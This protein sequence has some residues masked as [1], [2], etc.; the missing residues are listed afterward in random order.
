[1]RHFRWFSKC[2]TGLHAAAAVRTKVP[3]DKSTHHELFQCLHAADKPVRVGNSGQR[4]QLFRPASRLV[5]VLLFLLAALASAQTVF[6]G[7]QST[8]NTGST[9][10]SPQQVA[11]DASGDVFVLDDWTGHVSEMVAVNAVIPASPTINVLAN[12]HVFSGGGMVI[13][14][15]GNLFLT[16]NLS[17][18][19]YGMFEIP[20]SS[21]NANPTQLGGSFNTSNGVAL[22]TSGNVYVCEDGGVNDIKEISAASGYTTVTTPVTGLNSPT[23]VAVDGSGNIF[24]ADG[25]GISIKEFTASSSYASSTSLSMSFASIA[26]LAIDANGNLYAADGS[27]QALDE[28]LSAGGYST[29]VTLASGLTFPTGVAVTHSGNVFLADQAAVGA[30]DEIQ[31][32]AV[33]FG[34]VNMGSTGT[35]ISLTFAFTAAETIAAPSVLTQGFTGLDF[36]DAGTGTCT[37]NGT[38]HVYQS[39]DTCTVNVRFSPTAPRARSGSVVLL[40]SGSAI[41]TAYLTGTGVG[42]QVVFPNTNLIEIGAPDYGNLNEPLSIAVD[43]VGNVYVADYNFTTLIVLPWNCTY[44][45][46]TPST[47]GG[48]FSEPSS[49]AIDGA[50]NLYVADHGNGAIKEMP[51]NCAD[52]TCVTTLGGSF[53]QPNG[54]AVDSSGNVYVSDTGNYRVV[55]MPPGCTSSACVTP[56]GGGFATPQ[57]LWVDGSGNV[58]VADPYPNTVARYLSKIPQGC[59]SSACTVALGGGFSHPRGVAVDGSGNIYIADTTN[60]KLKEMPGTCTTSA[61]VTTLASSGYSGVN[62]PYG[63]FMTPGN[64]LYVTD[65]DNHKIKEIDQTDGPSLSYSSTAVGAS[66]TQ[67]V[68]ALSNYGNAPLTISALSGSS[69]NFSGAGTTCAI[70]TPLAA[71]ASCNLGIKFAPTAPGAPLTGSANITDNGYPASQ[72]IPVSGTATGQRPTVTGISPATGTSSGGT[73]ITITGSYFYSGATVSFGSTAATNVTV[74]SL[75]SMTATSPAGSSS[76][77]VTVTTGAGTSATGSPDTFAYLSAD[78]TATTVAVSPS[79]ILAGQTVAVTAAVADSTNGG[80]TPTGSVTFTDTVGSTTTNLNSGNPVSLASGVATLSSVA[81]SGAGT[82]TIAATYA[83]VNGT[84]A[85]SSGSATAAVSPVS[86]VGTAGAALP[87]TLTF[88]AAGTVSTI[89]VL[90]QGAANL[91]FTDGVTGD[92]CS[93]AYSVAGTCTVNVV[94]TPRYPGLRIGAVQLADSSGNILATA[95]VQGVGTAPQITF[96]KNNVKTTL[97]GSFNYPISIALDGSANV[98]L[99]DS[100]NV[101][102]IVAAGGYA[103]VHTLGGGFSFVQ[104]AG[105][106]LDGAGNLIVAD[107]GNSQVD[108]VMAKGGYTTVNVLAGYPQFNAPNGLAVDGSGNIFVTDQV[109]GA[110]YEMVAASGYATIKTLAGGF[111][112]PNGVAVDGSGNVYVADNGHNAIKELVAVAGVI[113]NSPT[114]LT[115]GGGFS[116]PN[117]VAVGANGAVFVADSGHSAVKTMPAGC[118]SSACVSILGGGFSSPFGVAL[119]GNGNLFLVDYLSGL[120]QQLNFSSPPSLSFTNTIVGATSGAMAVSIS[121]GGNAAFNLAVSGLNAP[122]DYLQV[123]GSGTPVDC[124]N[125][126]IV[127]SGASCNLSI[128]FN[129]L[130]TGLHAEGFGLADNNLGV[131]GATQTIPLS[132]TGVLPPVKLALAGVPA[133]ITSGGSFDSVTVDVENAD[134]SVVTSSSASVTV[135][136]T[137][138]GGFTHAV[139]GAAVNGVFHAN[140][141]SVVLSALG[142]YTVTATSSSLTSAIATVTVNP[143]QTT[144]AASPATSSY[145]PSSGSVTLAALVTSRSGT[146]N[147]GTVTF[148]VLSG[149][150]PIGSAVTSGTV[151]NGSAGAVYMLPSATAA[152]TYTIHAVYNAGGTFATSTDS[153]HT[154]TVAKASATITLGSLAQTYTGSALSA[155]ATTSPASLAV[156]F[157]YDGS[158]T[159]PT[160]TGSYAVV[161]TINDANYAGSAAGTLV[162][163]KATPTITLGSLAQT[164]TGSPLSATAATT[165]ASLTVGFTYNGSA[166]PPTTAGSYTVVATINDQNYA[167]TATG[168]LVISKATATITLGSLAQTYTGSA[169][170]ATATTSP[171]SLT[172]SFTYNGSATPPTAA[173][174]YTVVAT[175]NDQNYAGSATGALVISKA[176]ASITLGSLAQ[177]YTGSAFSATAT[178][179]PASLAVSFTYNGS[180]APPST[181]GSYTVVATIND[182]NYTGSASGALVIAKAGQSISFTPLASPVNYIAPIAL[183]ATGGASGNPVVFSV[184]TGSASVSGSQLLVA[185]PGTL[186]VAANQSGS[187]NYTAGPQVTQT[188]VSIASNLTSNVS[189]LNFGNVPIGTASPSQTVIGSN[190]NGFPVT[191]ATLAANG[192]FSAASNC[193][194]IAG[195][196]T[197]SINVTF[198]PTASGTRSGTLTVGG[199]QLS[200]LL[201]AALSGTGA[202]AGIQFSIAALDFGSVLSLSTSLGQTLTIQNT[203]TTSLIVSRVAT[204]GDFSTT[205]NCAVIPAGSN[206]SLSVT[207][208]PTALG[209]RTGAVTLTDNAG[210][211]ASSQTINLAGMGTQAGAT[212][213][214]SAAAFPNTPAGST[215]FLINATLTNTGTVPLT[216]IG[217]STLGDFRQ[218]NTCQSTLAAGSTCIVSVK[219]APTVAGAESGTLTVIDNLG[220][221][222]VSLAGTGVVPG[223]SLSSSQLMFGGQLINTSS[224]AQTV[225]FT[226]TGLAAIDIGSVATTSNFTDSTN[227]TGSV[228]PGASCSVNVIFT[229]ATTGPLS[230]TVT[231][232]DGAGTQAASLNGQGTNPGL[233]VSPSFEIFGAQVAGTTS[234]AQTLTVTNTGTAA[235]TLNPITVSNNLIESDQCPAIFQPGANCTVSLSFSPTSTGALSGS[236]VISDASGLVSTLVTAAGQGTL[237]GI[238]TSPS[239]LSFGSLAVGTTSQ[240]QTVTV[241][242]TGTAPLQI[243]AVSGTGDFAET[244]TCSSQTIAAGS[245]CVISVTMTP[246]T[247]GTRTGTIQFNDSADGLHAIALNGMGQQAGVSVTPTGLAFG[248]SPIVSSAQ[249]ASAAGTSLSVTISNTGSAPLE[250]GGFSTQGDFTEADNCGASV[251]A[252]A[253]CTLS[254]KF[255]PTALGHRTGTLTITDNAGGGSQR[256]SLAGDG[257]PVGLILTPPIINFGVQPK[258]DTSKAQ[259]ATLSNNTGTAISDLAIFASGEYSEADNCGTALANGASCTVN[260]TVTPATTGAVTGTVAISG[261]GVFAT[262]APSIKTPREAVGYTSASSISNVGVVATLAT[263]NG[264][265]TASQLAFGTTPTPVV[266]AGGNAGSSITVL[267]DDSNGNP[268]S[269]TDTITLTVTGPGGFSKTYTATASGGI[270]SFNLSGNALT[271]AGGYTY[272][273]SI[274]PNTSI[275]PAAAG[276]MVYV[277][278]AASVTAAA[279]SGQR[280]LTNAAFATPLQVIVKDAYG[281]PVSGATVTFAV[282]STGASARLSSGSVKSNSA[283]TA[284]VTAIANTSA[285]AYTVTATVSGLTTASFSL[286]NASAS[287]NVVVTSSSV[288]S[289]FESAVTFTASVSATS[290]TPT[291]TVNFMDGATALGSG[292]MS[293]GGA[294]YSTSSLAAGSHTITA[295]YGGDTNYVAASS[296]SLAQMVIDYTVNAAVPA[297]TVLPGAS[298]SYAIGIVPTAGTSLPATATLTVTGMPA[299]ATAALATTPWT[300]L[301]STSWQVPA[302]T[303]LS[304]V[305]LTIQ[306][307]SQ[308]TSVAAQG[309]PASKMPPLLWGILLLPFAG[310]LRRAGKRMGRTML[311]L[312]LLT[313]GAAGIAGLTGCGTNNGFFGQP[314]KAYNITVTVTAGSLSHSTHLTLTVQ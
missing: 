58:F 264:N 275:K 162:I 134:S 81:L 152:G 167:G 3:D 163:G 178:T 30:I 229:P 172:V 185:G 189:A 156:T 133:Q 297:R 161:G 96:S 187:A 272:T 216:G 84:L 110:V 132:G 154:L 186:V 266:A 78:I 254:V 286:T 182:Q 311:L 141:S 194:T 18:S 180:S 176:S 215:G 235:L 137:G 304:Q 87:V 44:G 164:Y 62:E 285:G 268:V 105:V 49:V 66:S 122:A 248:S 19:T 22:D 109:N 160:A 79:T 203:G 258:G 26:N 117:A 147:A 237:P 278:P 115:L 207:F 157:T 61:C 23:G 46:C 242:N 107:Y 73:A 244:D 120:T 75:T 127:A 205:G 196:G 314:Q 277:G 21:P 95:Y 36:A 263:T 227:C 145:S 129:P 89:K 4:K 131:T 273:V 16:S 57:G 179:S 125:S 106:A 224:L 33:N 299:G 183:S 288:I 249:V 20:A 67:Q 111:S 31:R 123:A 69:A 82:H 302:G 177:T 313:A 256:I 64:N 281:N 255:A 234:Q 42:P 192:D 143:A 283:G 211:S 17:G 85:A 108:Q 312:L 116:S 240:G 213:T 128:A 51:L 149:S 298:A 7:V 50:G 80:T 232:T 2:L 47:V 34:T 121:N 165:P 119:N 188:V 146:V 292:T 191:G 151:A 206:C 295:V 210:G 259:T 99:A 93:G 306:A 14:A 86:N 118:A 72:S 136:V 204:S 201:T 74:V 43:G 76:V 291:G 15:N 124:A 27:N 88:T 60:S 24:V 261:G 223:A 144:I 209:A 225:V 197:C 112:N 91:D 70:S 279:G 174:S 77:D 252:A 260:I 100:S 175:I 166:T 11:V 308:T 270:A 243:G 113:P 280:A 212:L 265:T 305:P 52:A 214:P 300:Q 219:Y 301:T 221:Q 241:T 142:S 103:T 140:L 53:N 55:E 41:G 310:K 104:L 294:I 247:V 150:T 287:T 171:A 9:F 222:I 28:I 257:S 169:F 231:I 217:V 126:S 303:T 35:P 5:P 130:S 97:G 239:T 271:A 32:P 10:R 274:G 159:P 293:A 135:T 68:V 250:L 102:E 282:P 59:I 170:S 238:T 71:G 12:S 184:L 153:S 218:T 307:P 158:S 54:V 276:V 92:S 138:P 181:A 253:T 228:A 139:T 114:V 290:G 200:G 38:S 13:D 226:N 296:S 48:G 208:T 8:L 90:T 37:T 230:G 190:P 83:G 98:F 40:S 236:M 246:T 94:F 39:G 245:Y 155:T 29:E 25:N 6:V 195:L 173:G 251:A 193:P 63:V 148:T 1:M 289:L 233:A 220:S 267:E 45:S 56:I 65:T 269:A 168:A 284:S 202:T 309:T 198:T 199:S 262:A 101:R